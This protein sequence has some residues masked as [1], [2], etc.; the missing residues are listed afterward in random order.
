MRANKHG[1]RA[2]V[3]LARK[4]RQKIN[5]DKIES[6]KRE[7]CLLLLSNTLRLLLEEGTEGVAHNRR[8]ARCVGKNH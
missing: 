8:V 2:N 5:F 1:L 4:Q 6:L 3:G 7:I